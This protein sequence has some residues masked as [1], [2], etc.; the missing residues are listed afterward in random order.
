M[1]ADVSWRYRLDVPPVSMHAA[2]DDSFLLVADVFGTVRSLNTA[3]GEVLWERPFGMNNVHSVRATLDGGTTV[4]L[5]E[6]RLL[7]LD[8]DGKDQW[9]ASVG[10]LRSAFDVSADGTLVALSAAVHEITDGEVKIGSKVTLHG[11]GGKWQKDFTLDHAVTR[12]RFTSDRGDLVCTSPEGYVTFLKGDEVAKQTNLGSALD[13]LV[14]CLDGSLIL[15]PAGGDGIHVLSSTM[16]SLGVLGVSGTV[17]DVDVSEDGSTILV[18]E[19]DGLIYLLDGAFS[20]RW[21]GR[22]ERPVLRVDLASDG[23]FVYIAESTGEILRVDFRKRQSPEQEP[24][25]SVEGTQGL[26]PSAS[27]ELGGSPIRAG[28]GRVTFVGRTTVAVVPRPSQLLLVGQDGTT[29]SETLP[30]H[31]AHATADAA[32]DGLAVWSNRRLSL[33]NREGHVSPV[34]EQSVAAVAFMHDGDLVVGTPSGELHR[35]GASGEKTWSTRVGAGVI[36][37][38]QFPDQGPLVVLCADGCVS[39]VDHD[40]KIQATRELSAPSMAHPDVVA[41]A[42]NEAGAPT[43]DAQDFW[44][45]YGRAYQLVMTELGPVLYHGGGRVLRLNDKAELDGEGH[46]GQELKAIYPMAHRLFAVEAAGMGV[47]LGRDL[48]VQE[49]FGLASRRALP[50][51]FDGEPVILDATQDEVLLLDLDGNVVA[52]HAVYPPP[53]ELAVSADGTHVAVV[54]DTKLLLFDLSA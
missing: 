36:G 21:R 33:V 34:S 25:F 19:R 7:R 2:P 48:T 31:A 20:L 14:S 37:V 50:A 26:F 42:L 32:S 5:E 8:R 46:V 17:E 11:E 43:V 30:F 1:D 3:S 44:S 28:L 40:G 54:L 6:G 16:A 27:I 49:R 13:G 53:R 10:A 9:E 4:L 47:V 29:V 41:E 24:T 22:M 45:H 23:K 39:I 51:L 35:I 52:H 18:K 15:M 38:A 12:I